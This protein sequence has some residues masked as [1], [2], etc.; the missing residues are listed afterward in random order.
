MFL[1]PVA[2]FRCA[3]LISYIGQ[4][5][6]C[7]I[8]EYIKAYWFIYNMC[9]LYISL[10]EFPRRCAWQKRVQ[11]LIWKFGLEGKR[12]IFKKGI[13]GTFDPGYKILEKRG[14]EGLC[15]VPC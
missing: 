10:L 11:M 12:Y 9:S 4:I 6:I 8:M 7:G 13:G 15:C 5:L 2:M 1:L 14:L 3:V